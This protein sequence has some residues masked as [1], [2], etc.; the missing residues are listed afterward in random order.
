MFFF[1]KIVYNCSMRIRLSQFRAGDSR[2]DAERN[3]TYFLPAPVN[4]CFDVDVPA[5]AAQLEKTARRLAE[6]DATSKMVPNLALFRQNF[7]NNEAVLSSRIEGTKTA[8]EDLFKK[9]VE[10]LPE[11]RDD[12]LEVRLYI[13][14]LQEA[15]DTLPTLPLC[16]R[17][18]KQ[19]HQTLLSSGRGKNKM[20][21]EFRRS[22]NWIGGLSPQSAD[23]IPPHEQHV[24]ELMGDLEKF[25]NAKDSTPELIRIGIAHY[26]FETIH[27]FLDGNGRVGRMLI[28][29]FLV[30]R[31]LLKEPLLLYPSAFLERHREIYFMK[32]ARARRES[33]LAG[34]LLFFLE[35]MEFTAQ[36]SLDALVKLLRL[37]ERLIQGIGHHSG[38]RASNT[39]RVLDFAFQTPR[40]SAQD[41]Q[42]SLAVS[43]ATAYNL[44]AELV[45][46]GA[47]H[48]ESAQRRNQVFRF[49]PYLD[50]F[51][52]PDD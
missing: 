18:I 8:I 23:F 27:P 2:R 21:G 19:A 6:L 25:L 11:E 45:K 22:Q 10:V 15:A 12:L 5:L 37:R 24:E 36:F 17:L 30:E 49:A 35:G 32:L 20:P 1:V 46:L 7:I 41:L 16:N 52:Q 28:V 39:L 50:I 43:P 4:A 42:Q 38:R 3:Y 33:D 13:K 40:F 31:G 34:W 44:I 14:A 9:E 26:Q 29:L 51:Q 48:K 47:L